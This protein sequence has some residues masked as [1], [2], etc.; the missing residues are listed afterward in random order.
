[1][2]IAI[3]GAGLAGVSAARKLDN[4]AEVT[5]FEKSRGVSGR[6]STRRAD[7]FEFD[8]GAQYFTAKDTRFQDAI[9]QGVAAGH[10]A[11]WASNGVYLREGRLEPDTG[12]NRFVS[13]P[14][15]NSWVKALAQGLDVRLATRVSHIERRD[16]LWSLSFEDG[17]SDHGFDWVIMAAPS[18][19]V[20]AIFPKDFAQRTVLEAV[21]MDA[22][23][24]LMLGLSGAPNV[25]WDTLRQADGPAAWIAVNSAKPERPMGVATLMVHSGPQWSEDHI[26][27]DR[28]DIAAQMLS[29][30]SAVT[31]LNLSNPA[32][33]TLHFWRYAAVKN[34]AG[35]GCLIDHDKQLI[36]AGDWCLGGRVEGAYLSGLATAEAII[37]A[38]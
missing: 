26:D 25:P 32:Y 21:K 10:L 17:G 19:Q 11:P 13:K 9:E 18:E 6:M 28:G 5:V 36:A 1:M 20:E 3:I 8:H 35:Q 15:M 27:D 30:A 37:G 22:C 34:G 31:G 16:D 4:F 2:K 14:R 12:A 23:F 7:A 24:A 33:Q 29:A 38:L